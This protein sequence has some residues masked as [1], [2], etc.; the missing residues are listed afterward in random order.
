MLLIVEFPKRYLIFGQRDHFTL[1][2]ILPYV[3]A[4]PSMLYLRS[5]KERIALGI[6]A[7]LGVCFMPQ[8][9]LIVVAIEGT[10]VLIRR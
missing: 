7:G 3:L 8:E 6:F 4:S 1:I 5:R 2:C 9:I 10:L